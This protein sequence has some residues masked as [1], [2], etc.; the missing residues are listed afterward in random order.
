MGVA[1]SSIAIVLVAKTVTLGDTLE[2]LRRTNPVVFIPAA[3]LYFVG[4]SVRSLRWRV[5]LG[6][7]PVRLGLLFRSFVIGFT[8]NDLLPAR[9]GEL[10]RI[11]ILSQR[12]SIP[13]GIS[14]ASII[15]ERVLDGLVV[16]A[17]LVVGLMLVPGDAALQQLAG[18]AGVLFLGLTAAMLV[19]AFVPGPFR[20]LGVAV[21]GLT[22]GR[23]R[24]RLT[25]LVDTT[26][27]GL[28][29]IAAW[30]TALTALSLSFVVW[31]IEAV[32]Y[33]IMLSTF[34]IPGGWIAAVM[35]T[36][37]GNLATLLP[38]SPG[39]IGTFEWAV[40]QALVGAFGAAPAD[41]LTAAV[42]IHL[43]V[44]VPVV[45]VGLWLIWQ[46]GFTL[47]SLSQVAS[48]PRGAVA[49]S[50]AGEVGR[51]EPVGHDG[52]PELE[53]ERAVGSKRSN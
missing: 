38:S 49:G 28:E 2:S 4:I 36:G 5:L 52:P 43:A 1:F 9:L 37:V 27:D 32:I 20:R 35:G 11:V 3:A 48:H 25:R 17:F 26:L 16:T 29:A 42:V 23:W 21:A 13:T 14:F 8:V 39:Y 7:H 12:A 47:T 45:P 51:A 15:A 30:R 53:D 19:A 18:A 41:A 6:H 50:A 24:E 46:E 40:Q 44:V 34:S 10:A 31:G 33:W 22:R